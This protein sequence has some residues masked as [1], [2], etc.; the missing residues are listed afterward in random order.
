MLAYVLHKTY[1][2]LNAYVVQWFAVIN[3][4]Y[5]KRDNKQL[6]HIQ[7]EFASVVPY[8]LDIYYMEFMLLGHTGFILYTFK[9]PT[10]LSQDV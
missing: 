5:S 9:F 8:I 3:L 10:M 1:A 4:F 6:K 7:F 2:C